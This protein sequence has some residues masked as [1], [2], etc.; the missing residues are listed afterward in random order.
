IKVE[1]YHRARVPL[2]VIVDQEKEDGPRRLVGYRDTPEGYVP[3]VPDEQGRLALEPLGVLLGLRDNRI[4]C[5]DATSGEEI[6]GYAQLSQ[7]IVAESEARKTAE[8]QAAAERVR[9]RAAQERADAAAA[10]AQAAE[11]RAD[12]EARARAFLEARIQELEEQ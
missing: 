11:E 2:Y 4:V 3:L 7:A 9:A 10:I 5:Y 6:P 1:H 12:A 8:Q